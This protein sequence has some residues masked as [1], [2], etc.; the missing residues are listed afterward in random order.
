MA[1]LTNKQLKFCDEYIK[2]GNATKSAVAAGYSKKT[3]YSMANQLLKKLEVKQYIKAQMDEIKSAKIADATE[4]LELLSRIARGEELEE[5]TVATP[6]GAE[7][8]QQRPTNRDKIAACKELLK[9][10]PTLD[11][12]EKVQLAK[13]KAEVRIL[14]AKALVAERLSADDN[15]QLDAILEK[16]ETAM[17][18]LKNA[19]H[20]WSVYFCVFN[21]KIG[22]A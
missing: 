13:V 18:Q 14:E 12:R 1:K 7:T 17:V 16:I 9:R 20:Q 19:P 4:I 11:E 3:A 8:V 2:S 22:K 5:I 6:N 21:L 15:K 10:F